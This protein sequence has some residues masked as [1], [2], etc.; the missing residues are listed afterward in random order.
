[1]LRGEDL[2]CKG[3]P[4]E[5]MLY[6]VILQSYEAAFSNQDPVLEML[7]RGQQEVLNRQDKQ[8]QKLDILLAQVQQIIGVGLPT[9]QRILVEGFGEPNIARDRAAIEDALRVLPRTSRQK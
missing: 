1:M 8:S 9:L 4:G 2:F 5:R 6:D 7:L 3:T